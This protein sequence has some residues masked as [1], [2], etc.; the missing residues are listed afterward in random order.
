MLGEKDIS[1]PK[2][3]WGGAT[4]GQFFEP[5]SRFSFVLF[6]RRMYVLGYASFRLSVQGYS[7]MFLAS[8]VTQGAE[9]SGLSGLD[10]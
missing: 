3:M 6:L 10:R 8:V 4:Q 2:L 1:V 5:R 7:S 9:I